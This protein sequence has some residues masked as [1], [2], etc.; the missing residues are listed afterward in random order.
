MSRTNTIHNGKVLEFH[1]LCTPFYIG[2]GN[3]RKTV[4]RLTIT[5]QVANAVKLN[6]VVRMPKWMP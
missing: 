4:Y 3:T 5:W 1:T 2:V 6:G